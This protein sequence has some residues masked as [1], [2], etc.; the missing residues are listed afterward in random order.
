MRS[1]WMRRLLI[2][3]A[4]IPL[5]TLAACDSKNTKD[6][7]VSA[8]EAISVQTYRVQAT[9]LVRTIHAVGTIRH[10]RETPLGFT[11][12]GKVSYLRYDVGDYV[13]RGALI[14]ALDSTNVTADLS[15]ANA[16]RNRAQSEFSRIASLYKDGWVTKSQYES[17]EAALQAASAR[18]QQAGFASGTSRL[19]APSS[20]VVLA[21]YVQPGQVVAAGT[22]ALILGQDDEGFVFRAPII[23]SDAAKLIVGMPAQLTIEALGSEPV[24]AA[25]S[26]IDGRANQETGAFMV[27]FRINARSGIRSGQIGSAA[28]AMPAATDGSLQIPASALF[29]IR[30]GEGLVYVVDMKTKRV[31]TRNVSIERLTDGF[32]IVTGGIAVGDVIVVAG[33]EKLRS[34]AKVSPVNAAPVNAPP[35]N[36]PPVNT[37][38]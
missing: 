30:T 21:R 4:A 5:L 16:E 28:I 33:T 17:A 23:D 36:A 32:V 14:G 18:V 29:G 27:Q 10:R 22:A 13:K 7:K 6:G 24:A 1:F 9:N 15:V 31:E 11:S 20:G 26:E 37:A 12:S 35:V 19:Y 25:I 38:G 8:E 3:A 2:A 34:G